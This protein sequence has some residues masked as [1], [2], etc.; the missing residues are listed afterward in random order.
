MTYIKAVPTSTP[1]TDNPTIGRILHIRHEARCIPAIVTGVYSHD[2]QKVDI[3]VFD[4]NHTYTS[5]DR[6]TIFGNVE[7]HWPER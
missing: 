4:L 2:L 6:P 3:T 7:W 5:N 1:N